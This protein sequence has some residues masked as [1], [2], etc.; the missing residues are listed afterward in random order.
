MELVDL[1]P[2]AAA[3]VVVWER[4]GSAEVRMQEADW[5]AGLAASG[6]PIRAQLLASDDGVHLV[7]PALAALVAN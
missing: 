6:A 4:H 2:G 1:L 3:V 5:I 7:D